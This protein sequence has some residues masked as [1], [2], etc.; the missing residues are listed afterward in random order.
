MAITEK[1]NRAEIWIIL[2][3]MFTPVVPVT[4]RNAMYATPSEN[5]MQNKIMNNGLLKPPL[6]VLGKN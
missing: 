3:A 1:T 4:P 2:M 5:T 6:N